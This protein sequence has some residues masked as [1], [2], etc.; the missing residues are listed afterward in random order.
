MIGT[1]AGFQTQ[2]KQSHVATSKVDVVQNG[3]IVMTLNVHGGSV[4]ADRTAAQLRRFD[5]VV[6][7]PDGTL[8]PATVTDALS[9]FGTLV[10]V[11]RGVRV[12]D[13]NEVGQTFVSQSDWLTGT[14]DRMVATSGGALQLG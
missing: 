12:P 9:P 6:A 4:D 14:F 10:N 2:V 7:D 3:Q 13:I 11:Y 8:S 1:S 5:A